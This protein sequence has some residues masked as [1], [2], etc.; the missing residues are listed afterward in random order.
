MARNGLL[1]HPDVA[2]YCLTVHFQR[3]FNGCTE[4]LLYQRMM[5]PALDSNQIK[6]LEKVLYLQG[7]PKSLLLDLLDD[8]TF[9]GNQ[10]ALEMALNVAESNGISVDQEKA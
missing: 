8:I 4:D 9:T 2:E 3:H 6:I 5:R 10:E 1:F 7:I